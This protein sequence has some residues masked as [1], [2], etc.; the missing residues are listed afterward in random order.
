MKIVILEPNK[1]PFE[2]MIENTL[3]DMQ[4][5][6][7]GYIETVRLDSELILA[8]NA[9]GKMIGLPYNRE[10]GFGK[11]FVVGTCFITAS[12]NQG[13]FRDLTEQ[14][15]NRAIAMFD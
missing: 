5:V 12:D 13:E 9:D 15:V 4:G 7:G 8:Y 1:K 14:E 6:V 11:G 10:L 2:S 3:K